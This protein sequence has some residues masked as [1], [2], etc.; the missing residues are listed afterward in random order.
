[1]ILEHKVIYKQ[2]K[3][4]WREIEGEVIIVDLD[5]ET[6]LNLNETGK[7]IWNSINGT[8]SAADITKKLTEIYE[9]EDA[10]AKKDVTIFID[11]LL[12]KGL[13]HY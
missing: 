11:K 9:V 12:E 3:L 4:P 8:L 7:E 13:I 5:K 10:Q 6:V 1:M 2:K